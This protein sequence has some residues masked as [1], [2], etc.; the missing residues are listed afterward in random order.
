MNITEAQRTALDEIALEARALDEGV[1]D[2]LSTDPHD[3]ANAFDH[4]ANWSRK[5]GD[6]EHAML[7]DD[8]A[9][10]VRAV[11]DSE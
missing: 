8:L 10:R 11:L 2:D 7:W 9:A 1:R 4:A 6:E 3:W 5:D